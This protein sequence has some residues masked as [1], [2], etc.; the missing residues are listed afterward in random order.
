[1][2][3]GLIEAIVVGPQRAGLLTEVRRVRVHAGQGIDE[4]APL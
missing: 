2:E 1:M 4:V 3:T